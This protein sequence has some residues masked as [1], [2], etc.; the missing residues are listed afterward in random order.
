[1]KYFSQLTQET[2]GYYVY[3]LINPLDNKIFY[4]GKGKEVIDNTIQK[5]Y[6][7]KRLP[8][9]EKGQANPI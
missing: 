1:M 9:K 5:I 8:K 3:L 7:H 6:L 4:V 2:L